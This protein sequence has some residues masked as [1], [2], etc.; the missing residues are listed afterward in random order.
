ML[1]AVL[2]RTRQSSVLKDRTSEL[3]VDN[4][5]DNSCS[6]TELET[7]SWWVIDLGQSVKIRGIRVIDKP[8]QYFSN[9]NGQTNKIG[10]TM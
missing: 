6:V 5:N 4:D 8:F 7:G 9:V 1:T 3:A 10:L 2:D